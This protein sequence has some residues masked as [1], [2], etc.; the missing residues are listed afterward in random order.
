M[1]AIFALNNNVGNNNSIVE[2]R[3][4]AVTNKIRNKQSSDKPSN[5][6]N[7][8]VSSPQIIE[9][10]ITTGINECFS[11]KTSSISFPY[12]PSD[13]LT[14]ISDSQEDKNSVVS[15]RKP[16][17][18][19]VVH[20]DKGGHLKQKSKS[21]PVI[22]NILS[23]NNTSTYASTLMAG[24][25]ISIGDSLTETERTNSV[26][27]TKSNSQIMNELNEIRGIPVSTVTLDKKNDTNRN[28]KII[29]SIYR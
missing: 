16:Q 11:T 5:N 18:I 4:S 28:I 6:N 21:V 12:L 24:S 13:S 3:S 22:K 29:L 7:N 14:E 23:V 8:N 1:F 19:L 10:K 9:N 27:E 15:L 20:D 25:S 17:S 2:N 26:F